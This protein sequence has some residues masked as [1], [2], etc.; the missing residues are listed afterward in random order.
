MTCTELQSA[1]ALESYKTTCAEAGGTY[2]ATTGCKTAGKI[3]GCEFS[4]MGVKSSTIWYYEKSMADAQEAAC[5]TLGTSGVTT[6][7]VKP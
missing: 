4:A 5:P 1:A 3:S 2:S 6:K 7:V